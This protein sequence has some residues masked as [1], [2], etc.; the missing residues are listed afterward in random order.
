M[1][2]TNLI[3]FVSATLPLG[4]E[5][6]DKSLTSPDSILVLEFNKSFAF[7]TAIDGGKTRK[8]CKIDL[9]LWKMTTLLI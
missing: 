2:N 7:F 1:S 5:V 8:R 9:S 3:P 6:K 4:I